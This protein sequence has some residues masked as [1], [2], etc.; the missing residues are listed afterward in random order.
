[1]RLGLD[2]R[3]C[4]AGIHRTV[5]ATHQRQ[6]IRLGIASRDE[7]HLHVCEFIPH[8]ARATRI[9]RTNVHASDEITGRLRT[10][11]GSVFVCG[12]RR[13]ARQS[14]NRGRIPTPAA[15]R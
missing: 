11:H 1:M 4:L 2:G 6:H 10:V 14:L 5:Y 3:V 12:E 7:H 13:S 15:K 8:D 9:M